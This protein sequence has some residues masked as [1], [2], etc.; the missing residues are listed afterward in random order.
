[1]S[2]ELET[3]DQLLGGDLA[4]AVVRDL[5]SDAG[6]FTR[7]IAAMLDAGEV[8]LFASDGTEVPRWQWPEVLAA[9]S[10]HAGAPGARL[11]ITGTGARRIG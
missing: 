9:A 7:G 5:F 1:M 3:L 8:R 10:G 6:Q 11:A 4:L 2:P